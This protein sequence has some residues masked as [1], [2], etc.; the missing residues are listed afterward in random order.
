MTVS[1]KHSIHK[2]ICHGVIIP[3]FFSFA[4]LHAEAA[5]RVALVIGN[6]NYQHSPN[7]PNPV[8]DEVSSD[9]TQIQKPSEAQQVYGEIKNSNSIAVLEAFISSFPDSSYAKLALARISELNKQQAT[10]KQS[11]QQNI[12]HSKEIK[13][14]EI[15]KNAK[16]KWDKL[17]YSEDVNALTRFKSEYED[18]LYA[19]N[20]ERRIKYLNILRKRNELLKKEQPAIVRRETENSIISATPLLIS[21]HRT[22]S[23]YR[24]KDSAKEATCYV[25]AT[26]VRITP[27]DRDHG[28]IF[29]MLTKYAA[30]RSFEPH[31]TV[32]YP[33]KTSSSVRVKIGET[34]FIMFTK[35]DDAW[36]EKVSQEVAFLSA[37]KSA[38]N[39][40]LTGLT[41]RGTAVKYRF[42]LNGITAALN[43]L[44]KCS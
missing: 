37:M 9:Q 11:N 40:E 6:S 22:W 2:L 21:K 20:A 4:T 43:A 7:L 5:K 24:L 26:P 33:F 13:R 16:K 30:N 27:E 31:F 41:I 36:V 15:S 34:T 8:N 3:L 29:F 32:G 42:S 23:A 12:V 39:M 18:T 25:A 14:R 28:D 10:G 44:R 19:G 38:A 17:K 1:I 35:D